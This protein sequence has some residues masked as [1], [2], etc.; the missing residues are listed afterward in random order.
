[1]GGPVFYVRILNGY[2]SALIHPP[3]NE[4]SSVAKQ[5]LQSPR[6]DI[7]VTV[8][9]FFLINYVAFQSQN[10]EISLFSLIMNQRTTQFIIMGIVP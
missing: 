6:A 8:L 10:Y 5:S 1:M 9:G 3:D 2:L 4:S 7:P